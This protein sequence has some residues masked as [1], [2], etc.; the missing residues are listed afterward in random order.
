MR[1]R[2]ESG[3][4]L[5]LVFLMAALIA[6][7]LYMQVPR[8]A[9]ETQ[10]QK[11]QLLIER[12]EQ[13]KRAIGLFVRTNNGRWPAKIEELESFNNRRY[14]RKRFVDPMT[15]KNE[16]RLVHIQNGVLTDSLNN[17][18]KQ[19]G[20]KDK[21]EA[22]T[23]GQYVGEQAGIG[24]TLNNGQN[25]PVNLA[26]RRRPSD[27]GAAPGGIG[28]DGQPVPGLTGGNTAGTTTDP[29]MQPN[30]GAPQ[31]PG[32]PGTSQPYSGSVPG[33]VP[34]LVPPGLAGQSGMPGGLNSPYPGQAAGSTNAS[35]AYVGSGQAYVGG[36]ST[37][38]PIATAQPGQYPQPGQ[39]P[40]MP[41]G[42]PGAPGMPGNSQ[43]GSAINPQAQSA[44]AAMIS[45]ILTTPRPG[46]M[47]TSNPGAT[48]A[49]GG[50]IAG[51]ASTL[52]ADAIMIYNDQTDYAKWEF[53]FDPTKWTPPVNP[54]QSG[55]G[56]PASQLGS[57]PGNLNGLT[58]PNGTPAGTGTSP[59]GNTFGSGTQ[60]VAGPGK[61]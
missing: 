48:G 25:T 56:T 55:A 61:Q 60:P 4:A 40:G 53:I 10:R 34:G 32:M 22:T 59:F 6:I 23:A 17:K 12:G 21:K 29:G 11:E 47:P 51:V 49:I 19:P 45:Q 5:L 50:G 52:D 57:N 38:T 35:G 24:Q 30:P 28:P 31:F 7:T 58:N 16:W 1:R 33:G 15:G 54:N 20:D 43:T 39:F 18:Q 26:M 44:A 9:F 46:G 14:L 27:G 3:F 36:Y 42:V 2:K 13:Y 37:P 8:V 41:G